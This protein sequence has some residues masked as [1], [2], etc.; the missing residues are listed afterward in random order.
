MIGPLKTI[1]ALAAATSILG[2]AA[3]AASAPTEAAAQ[4]EQV[5]NVTVHRDVVY[6]EVDG[7]RLALDVYQPPGGPHPAIVHIH[8]GGWVAGSKDG[9]TRTGLFLAQRGF[10]T[11]AIDYRLAPP[12]GRWRAPAQIEDTRDAVLWVRSHAADYGALPGRV[13]ALGTS[14]G[15]Y[16][17]LM[18]ATTGT[19]G[20]GQVDAAAALSAPIDLRAAAEKSTDPEEV[21]ILDNYTGCSVEQCPEFFDEL[22]P[23]NHVDSSDA[24]IFLANGTEELIPVEQ[25]DAMQAALEEAGVPHE[26]QLVPG[27]V[28]GRRL[29]RAVAPRAVTFLKTHLEGGRGGEPP[30]PGGPR[31]G[32]GGREG[33][34]WPWAAAAL[35]VLLGIGLVAVVLRRGTRA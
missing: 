12:G 5:G 26:L 34:T 16:L 6:K 13:A 15:A 7:I 22:S 19:P 28:H 33:S 29:G 32:P 2:A 27:A 8:G 21:E 35:I 18:V 24:P 30:G 10:V 31:G 4:V 17:A 23:I 1:A 20:K 9:S 11:F 14:A 25:A 3:P